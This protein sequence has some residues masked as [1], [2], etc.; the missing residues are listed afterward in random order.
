MNIRTPVQERERGFRRR[1]VPEC[2]GE[3]ETGANALAS[4]AHAWSITQPTVQTIAGAEATLDGMRRIV[5]EL[6][7]NIATLLGGA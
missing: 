3:L 7:L 6:R 4:L 5:A 2:I 1:S